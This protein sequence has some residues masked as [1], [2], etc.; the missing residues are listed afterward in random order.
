V[1]SA[2]TGEGVEAWC[3]WLREI[4]RRKRETAKRD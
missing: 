2:T 1:T 4:V 3:L